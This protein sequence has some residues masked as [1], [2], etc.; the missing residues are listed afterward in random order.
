MYF[1]RH[2]AVV[3]LVAVHLLPF[4][5]RSLM[6][7]SMG[8]KPADADKIR[9]LT[10]E[11]KAAKKLQIEYTKLL[12][13]ARASRRGNEDMFRKALND[14]FADLHYKDGD[15]QFDLPQSGDRFLQTLNECTQVTVKECSGVLPNTPGSPNTRGF[16]TV[17]FEFQN[18]R[19]KYT[20]TFKE[21]WWLFPPNFQPWKVRERIRL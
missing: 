8:P 1:L 9:Q 5:D 20:R 10:S 15:S 4:A 21:E 6:S 16:F 3:S 18:E 14:F 7:Q 2:V 17:E 19:T 13:S 11:E 12:G